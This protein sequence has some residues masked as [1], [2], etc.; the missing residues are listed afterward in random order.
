MNKTIDKVGELIWWSVKKPGVNQFDIQEIAEKYKIPKKF[1]KHLPKSIRPC[2]AFRRATNNLQESVDYEYQG[3]VYTIK[4]FT[5]EISSGDTIVRKLIEEIIDDDEKS[6]S[7]EIAADLVFNKEFNLYT[8]ELNEEMSEHANFEPLIKKSIAEYEK[9]KEFYPYSSIR[10]FVRNCIKE[11]NGVQ[12][13]PRSGI[14]FVPEKYES[15][16]ETLE[17]VMNEINDKSR[18]AYQYDSE[19]LFFRQNIRSEKR[20]IKIIEN[21][22]TQQIDRLINEWETKLEKAKERKKREA[23]I[24]KAKKEINNEIGFFK[25]EVEYIENELGINIDI[26]KIINYEKVLKGLSSTSSSKLSKEK[27]EKIEKVVKKI[28]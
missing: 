11:L 18:A 16:L 8:Y 13:A 27:K 28:V 10:A 1:E 7:Y 5:R 17:K 14:Y 15:E 21:L 24:K 12:V 2:D 26:N 6:I 25:N 23:K 4:T 19:S 22:Y 20:S 9:N 3:M